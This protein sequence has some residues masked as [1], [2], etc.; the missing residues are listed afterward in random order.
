MFSRTTS[1][2]A[3]AAVPALIAAGALALPATAQATAIGP[4]QY[5]QGEVYSLASASSTAGVIYVSCPTGAAVGHPRA[6]QVVAVRQ[7]FPPAATIGYTGNYGN[8]IAASLISSAGTDAIATL[9]AYDTP[10]PIS[11]T[12][13][14]PCSG[15][16][17][18]TFTPVPNPD[19]SGHSSNVSVTFKQ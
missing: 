17:T 2:I 8:Q 1:R 13:T 5:F 9:T 6:G 10:E 15:T 19:S 14:V 3:L 4:R 7:L 12:I 11:T 18:M 16:G